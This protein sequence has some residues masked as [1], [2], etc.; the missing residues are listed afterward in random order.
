MTGCVGRAAELEWIGDA[1][2][3][4]EPVLVVGEAGIGKTT[5]CL[6]AAAATG[7]PVVAV[8]G[9]RSLTWRRFG[10][11]V[12][13][14][15]EHGSGAAP[16]SVAAAVR[17][18]V[19]RGVL[20][21]D[22]L[23]WADAGSLEVVA[24]LAGFIPLLVAVRKADPGAAAALAAMQDAG[25]E[26]VELGGLDDTNAGE[27]ARSLRPDIDEDRMGVVVRGARGNPLFV[28][29]LARARGVPVEFRAA[30]RGRIDALPG[31]ALTDLA[32]IALTG[33]PIRPGELGDLPDEIFTEGLVT[34]EGDTI[35]L[36]H[37]LVGEIV[38]EA[39]APEDRA[40]LHAEL[41]A[42]LTEDSEIAQHLAAAGRTEEARRLALHAA[43]AA[44]KPGEAASLLG[45]AALCAH[46]PESDELRLRAADALLDAGDF[47]GVIEV[48]DLVRGLTAEVRARSAL[49]RADALWES[50]R[51][52]EA[53]TVVDAALA[54]V[55]GS[56]TPVEVR[57]RV[58]AA[59]LAGLAGSDIAG[60]RKLAE[61]TLALAREIG[62][63]ESAALAE[64]GQALWRDG[65]RR[66]KDLLLR[67]RELAGAEGDARTETYALEGLAASA[68]MFG[69]LDEAEAAYSAGLDICRRLG[70]E[71]RARLFTIQR[72]WLDLFRGN[73]A[74]VL[75]SGAALRDE[76]PLVRKADTGLMTYGTALVDVGREQEAIE[77]ARA[78]RAT[79][80]DDFARER[81]SAVMAEGEYWGG[82]PARAVEILQEA[83]PDGI[84]RKQPAFMAV[85]VWAWSL[86]ELGLDPAA[87]PDASDR[88]RLLPPVAREVEAAALLAGGEAAAAADLLDAAA[89]PYAGRLLRSELRI[90][91]RQGEALRLAGNLPTARGVLA[92]TV[93]RAR[94][95]GM[96]ALVARASR[97]LRRAGGEART[98]GVRTGIALTGRE[99][100][101]VE[102]VGAGL[103]NEEI[104]RRLGVAP[105]TVAR[106]L[107]R[108]REKLGV[109]S[110][111]ATAVAVGDLPT[112]PLVVLSGAP[113]EY[114][115]RC[116]EL[117]AGGWIRV[118]GW[119]VS[120][121][122]PTGAG[123][124][125][126]GLVYGSADASGV[127]LAGLRGEAV[128]ALVAGNSGVG[129]ALVEDLG[130][131]GAVEHVEGDPPR[132]AVVR[133][134][135]GSEEHRL[136]RLLAEGHSTKEA[137][138][139]LHMAPRTVRHRLAR[140]RARLGVSSNMEAIRVAAAGRRSDV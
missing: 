57:L 48:I 94:R 131:I 64:A 4:C 138:R 46:G 116:G 19:G 96:E 43:A 65:C 99:G 120:P 5:L 82:R 88:T 18:A 108:A 119:E 6:Q 31:P 21:V 83:F 33:R 91:W 12:P 53:Q 29:E 125:R 134:E 101:V 8:A 15:E 10:P 92:D 105:S 27:L 62:A 2:M 1:L 106:H 130:R 109:R 59:R 136:L 44:A 115:A 67:A 13:L 118:E 121:E 30:L 124:L 77:I 39:L 60:A 45:L 84:G 133:V 93:G 111:T 103:S 71:G 113:G 63:E 20:V 98:N 47:L 52:D 70:L 35:W 122:D 9:F 51:G 95:A 102:L 34:T 14:L 25:F 104:A 41:A 75:E 79:A 55:A 58:E 36:R 37:A 129:Q 61:E 86:F 11:F 16:G 107:G 128:V 112:T 26:V 140:L 90:R 50:G 100:T 7:R 72:L 89:V 139:I 132:G 23:H 32:R 42:A 28:E 114:A 49:V 126:T 40:L 56:R 54:E 66:A 73:Y 97:S 137:G 74:R 17:A 24:H 78:A 22:D 69:N 38:L 110:R 80:G 3:E 123:V 68:L 117:A 127:V 81:A 87:I 85:P 76:A 135:I